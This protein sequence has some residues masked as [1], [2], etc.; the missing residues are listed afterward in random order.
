MYASE[1]ESKI[2]N[3][4]KANAHI[5]KMI[6]RIDD[7]VTIRSIHDAR[8]MI[9]ELAGMFKSKSVEFL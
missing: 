1:L 3:F 8:V 6:K 2:L 5:D 4:N 9:N 7:G